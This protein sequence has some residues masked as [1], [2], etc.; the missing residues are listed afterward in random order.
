MH[1]DPPVEDAAGTIGQHATVGFPAGRTRRTVM[2]QRMV[3]HVLALT[4]EEQTFQRALGRLIEF[5]MDLM[6]CQQCAKAQLSMPQA[7]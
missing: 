4:R 2:N 5:G 1:D 3:V 6:P 7:G